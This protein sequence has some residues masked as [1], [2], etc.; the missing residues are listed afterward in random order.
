MSAQKQKEINYFVSG[1]TGFIGKA[2]V[3]HLA[4][5]GYGVHALYRDEK[6]AES[7]RLPGVKLFRG[8]ILDEASI[9]T[10]MKACTG[11]FHLAAYAKVY[12]KDISRIY[13]LNIRGAVN[14]MKAAVSEGAG[15]VVITSTAGIFGPSGS[16]PV[17]EDS[18]PDGYFID[19]EHSKAILQEVVQSHYLAGV[20]VVSVHPT[21]VYG[22]GELSDSNGVTRMI[23]LYRKGKWRIIPGDGHSVGNYVY[24]EDVVQGHILAMEKGKRGRSYILGGENLSYKGLFEELALQTSQKPLMLRLP[25]PVMITAAGL[26]TGVTKITGKGPA[27][28]PALARK[29]SKNFEVSSERAMAELGYKPVPFSTGLLQTLNWLNQL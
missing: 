3:K 4:E 26:M 11:A 1:A 6:K 7:I 18:V 21:R 17:D 25:V 16:K 19:Y 8:D 29:F 15:R 2:L 24:I 27:I 23:D 20:D 28:T 9:R 12:E 5:H 22:P 10:A 13:H 14:V